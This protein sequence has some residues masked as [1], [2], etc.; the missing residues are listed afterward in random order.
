MT[1]DPTRTRREV[2]HLL[3]GA[4]LAPLWPT[5]ACGG[6][7]SGEEPR[8][9]DGGPVLVP[10][11]GLVPD[12]GPAIGWAVGGTAAMTAKASY[13]DPFADAPT[14]CT[15]VARTTA[16]PCTTAIDLV[17]EDVSEGWAGLPVRLGLKVVDATCEPLVGATV[18]IWHTNREGS[19]SG[20]TPA[21]GF[22]L[23]DQDYDRFDF[24]RGVGTTDADGEVFFDT[25]YPGWYPGRAIH[26][27]F[28]VARGATSTRVSQ[29]FFPEDLTQEIFADH[30]D[31]AEFGQ[32]DTVF[33]TDGVMAAIPPSDRARHVLT[34]ARMSDGAM[35]AS[36]VVTVV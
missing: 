1:D 28:Q 19:Y 33:T 12:A 14:T 26:I 23:L 25:C 36:K 20:Q 5:L 27:H 17:R 11:G 21:N 29:V 13:P 7:G 8:G 34:V 32:P 2:L 9:V 24:F 16:G 35:L 10:D 3:A 18:R 4:S 22:C 6:G 31:Y 15:L 30:A